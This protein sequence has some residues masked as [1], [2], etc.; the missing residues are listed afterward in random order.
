MRSS[1][2]VGCGKK[3][4]FL[5][6]ASSP[7]LRHNV[8]GATEPNVQYV[9]VY[10]RCA[11]QSC[12]RAYRTRT[13]RP[14]ETWTVSLRLNTKAPQRNTVLR[15]PSDTRVALFV[16]SISR[17][18]RT[19]RADDVYVL[20]FAKPTRREAFAFKGRPLDERFE[21]RRPE[22][23]PSE[24]GAHVQASACRVPVYR[25]SHRERSTVVRFRTG[26]VS[27]PTMTCRNT[28]VPVP[29]GNNKI[30]LRYSR[31]Y[32]AY[33]YCYSKRARNIFDTPSLQYPSAIS[34]RTAST[35]V[36]ARL[37]VLIFVPVPNASECYAERIH[38]DHISL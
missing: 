5:I 24:R 10:M 32:V 9:S 11:P 15:T 19:S 38:A 36:R 33:N 6:S 16:D 31:A 1:R 25:D 22:P 4:L 17:V 7:R 30:M 34:L 23:A 21:N 12:S 13:S 29:G 2:R 20:F 35:R 18:S 37:Q 8:T 28:H 27:Q 14:F 26:L 3:T